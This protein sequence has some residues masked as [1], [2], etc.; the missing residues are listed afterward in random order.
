MREL[1]FKRFCLFTKIYIERAQ[2]GRVGGRQRGRSRSLLS[3]ELDVGCDPR[4]QDPDSS[5][6]QTLNQLNHPGAPR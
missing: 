1:F 2:A 6:R 4:T 5:R 3:R